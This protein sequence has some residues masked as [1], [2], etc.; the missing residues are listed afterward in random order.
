MIPIYIICFNNGYYVKNT[1]NQ[2]IDNCNI[3]IIKKKI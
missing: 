2:L 1:V 3:K